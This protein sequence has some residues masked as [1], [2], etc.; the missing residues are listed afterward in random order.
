MAALNYDCVLLDAD[1]TIWDFQKAQRH[2]LDAALHDCGVKTPKD[3]SLD[4][5]RSVNK[6]LWRQY[7]AG[8]ISSD[9]VRL[10]RFARL[11]D[12]FDVAGDA[13]E[14][15]EVFVAHLGRSAFMI[16]GALELLE[17]LYRIVPLVLVTN[18]LSQVQRSR[19]EIS[20]IGRYFSALVIS[21]ETGIQKP[22]P[23]IFRIAVTRCGVG[24]TPRVLMV[25]DSLSSDIA[26]AL[27]AGYDACWFAPASARSIAMTERSGGVTP[28]FTVRDLAEIPPIVIAV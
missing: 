6:S 7:E 20:G 25:G 8:E 28:T 24:G 27:A 5:F 19:I 23:E 18:G 1:D 21:E 3:A 14:L 4:V 2:A 17:T 11:L 10:L 15:S 26:G 9:E 22:E 13:R 16:R 12:H